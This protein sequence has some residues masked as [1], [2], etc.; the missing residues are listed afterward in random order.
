M[1]C[2]WSSRWAKCGNLAQLF[3]CLKKILRLPVVLVRVPIAV[4][5]HNDQGNFDKGHLIGT[6]LQFQRFG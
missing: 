5:R 2:T 6:G 4:K 3:F 1:G